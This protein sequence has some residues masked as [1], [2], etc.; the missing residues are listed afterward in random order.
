VIPLSGDCKSW[1]EAVIMYMSRESF[2]P[3]ML[4]EMKSNRFS[5]LET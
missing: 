3:K 1:R 4:N 5:A 2:N